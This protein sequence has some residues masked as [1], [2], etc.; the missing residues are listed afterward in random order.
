MQQSSHAEFI[1]PCI[2]SNWPFASSF[3]DF[4]FCLQFQLFCLLFPLVFLYL[5]GCKLID[6]SSRQSVLTDG[7]EKLLIGLQ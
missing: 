1:S 7:S 4:H 6:I 2:L 5:L 3:P